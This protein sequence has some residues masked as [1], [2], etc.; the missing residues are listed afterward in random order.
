V[1][2]RGSDGKPVSDS[3]QVWLETDFLI[4]K[5]QIGTLTHDRSAIRFAY[6]PRPYDFA[7]RLALVRD[8]SAC[9][10]ASASPWA[11]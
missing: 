10:R 3:L 7:A 8:A 2:G 9:F 5:L 4:G 1:K 6:S 11:V